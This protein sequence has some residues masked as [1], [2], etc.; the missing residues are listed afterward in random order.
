MR[1]YYNPLIITIRY[2]CYIYYKIEDGHVVLFS[3][4]QQII[5]NVLWH[6]IRKVFDVLPML[7]SYKRDELLRNTPVQSKLSIHC[8]GQWLLIDTSG[9]Q[10]APVPITKV[11]LY[12]VQYL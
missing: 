10:D 3:T 1:I 7:T 12:I 4:R 9:K 5:E 8:F 6:Y 2:P 11:F